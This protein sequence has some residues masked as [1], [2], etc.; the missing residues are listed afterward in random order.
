MGAVR[1]DA[2]GR[3]ARVAQHAAARWRSNATRGS[4]SRSCSTNG[5]LRSGPSASASQPAGPRSCVAR[6]VPRRRTSIPRS[7][8]RITRGCRCWCARPTARR[9]CATAVPARPSIRRTS[10]APRSAGSTIPVRRRTVM[11]ATRGGAPSPIARSRTPIGS[12]PGPVHL[13]LPFREPL[14]PTGAPLVAAPGRAGGEPWIRSR[15][16]ERR[17]RSR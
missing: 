15:A 5:P 6:R 7:S 10:S 13:N 11:D 4:R 9:N 3:V 16:A 1:S 14:V 2:R 8:R 12:P 17:S